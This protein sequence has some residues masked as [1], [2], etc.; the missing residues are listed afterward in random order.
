MLPLVVNLQAQTNKVVFSV[1]KLDIKQYPV[2]FQESPIIASLK[3][4]TSKTV[5]ALA[6]ENLNEEYTLSNEITVIVSG[7]APIYDG[8]YVVTP[9]AYNSVI[10]GTKNKLCRDD[11]IV[12]KVP[13]RET[14]NDYGTTF[15]IAEV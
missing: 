12:L 10:L 3:V 5:F 2:A 15:Y 13:T 11:V 6:C 14:H 4:D 8:D 1:Q 7:D 9:Q